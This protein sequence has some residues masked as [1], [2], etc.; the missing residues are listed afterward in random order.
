MIDMKNYR[1]EGLNLVVLQQNKFSVGHISLLRLSE[2]ISKN[3]LFLLRPGAKT[4]H[5]ALIRS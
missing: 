4:P 5:Q 1:N 2:N 3:I